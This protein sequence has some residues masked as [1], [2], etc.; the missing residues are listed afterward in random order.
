VPIAGDQQ[1]RIGHCIRA[2]VA[3][4]APLEAAAMTSTTLGLLRSEAQLDGLAGR[5]IALGLTDGVAVALRAINALL[6][7][8]ES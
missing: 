3:V 5:A 6:T 7:A 4:A 8:P 2:G 1:E